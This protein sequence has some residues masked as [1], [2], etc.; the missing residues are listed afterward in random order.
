MVGCGVGQARSRRAAPLAQLDSPA[1]GR[2]AAEA[3]NS[4]DLIV[5]LAEGRIGAELKAA[6]ERGEVADRGKPINA[7]GSDIN[8][9]ATLS[10]LNIPRQRASEFKALHTVGPDVIREEVAAATAE[11]RRPSKVKLVPGTNAKAWSGHQPPSR[12]PG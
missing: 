3:R 6:Q 11:G 5:L 2:A 7:Q 1:A 9:P 10:D 12:W 4:T 8:E